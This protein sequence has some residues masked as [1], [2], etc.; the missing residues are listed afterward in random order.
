MSLAKIAKAAKTA[1]PLPWRTCSVCHALAT[2]PEAEAE[3]LRD[4]LRGKLRYSEISDLIADDP[5]TPLRLD[6]D[7]LSRHARGG[8][9]ARERLRKSAR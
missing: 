5:D 3:G 7:A 6:S 4:L 1:D 9:S 8:C 2:I